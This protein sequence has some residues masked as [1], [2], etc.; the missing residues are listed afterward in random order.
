M[1]ILLLSILAITFSLSG[2][3]SQKSLVEKPFFEIGDATYQSWSGG[4]PESGSGIK[5]E[6]PIIADN[7]A[8]VK[9]QQAFFRG[10]IATIRM[11][12]RGSN[13]MAVAKYTTKS[14]L[15]PDIVADRDVRKEVGNTPPVLQEKFP[16]EVLENECGIS[17]KDGNKIK[18]Y[19]I[20][21]IKEKKAAIYK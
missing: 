4:R 16:F 17:Y 20:T 1:R 11:E 8:N 15:K 5:L 2:C 13:W 21:G 18:Y 6:I 14:P 19:K 9:I 3:S 10:K 7:M 12:S